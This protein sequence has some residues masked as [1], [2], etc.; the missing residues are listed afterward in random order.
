MPHDSPLTNRRQWLAAA[1]V[2][3]CLA[4]AAAT[5]IAAPPAQKGSRAP[6]PPSTTY[7]GATATFDSNPGDGI[8]GDGQPYVGDPGSSTTRGAFLVSSGTYDDFRLKVAPKPDGSPDRWLTLDF[9]NMSVAPPNPC[10]GTKRRPIACR[11]DFLEVTGA[12]RR[13][14]RESSGSPP[15]VPP[16]SDGGATRQAQ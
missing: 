5:T 16:P 2:V 7:T 6:K 13:Q 15:E 14:R 8:R 3:V 11:K 9:R 4:A 1:S 12:R 10:G